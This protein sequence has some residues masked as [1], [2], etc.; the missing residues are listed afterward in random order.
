MKDKRRENE[1]VITSYEWVM[2]REGFLVKKE[3]EVNSMKS[4]PKGHLR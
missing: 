3:M 2:D 1:Q 4:D